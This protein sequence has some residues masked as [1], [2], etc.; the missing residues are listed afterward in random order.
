MAVS[1]FL[2]NGNEV[3]TCLMDMSKA[4]DTV[5]H[6]HLFRK[7]LEQGMPEIIVCFILVSYRYQKANVRWNGNE[8]RFFSIRNGVKQGAIL[9]A[10]LYCVYKS[11][12]IQRLRK[13]KI[14]CFVSG[15]FAGILGYAD[16]LF[17]MSPTLDGLQEMLKVCETYAETHNLKFSTNENPSKSKTKCYYYY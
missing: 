16:D 10:I 6:S 15:S 14:G 13:N 11:G 4:F 7:L 2:R 1:G 17:L 12:I 3:Y 8:S 9:S 5:Q